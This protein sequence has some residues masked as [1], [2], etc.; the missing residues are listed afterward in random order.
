MWDRPQYAMMSQSS[1]SPHLLGL[2]RALPLPQEAAEVTYICRYLKHCVVFQTFSLTAAV[3]KPEPSALLVQHCYLGPA[4]SSPWASRGSASTLMIP[5]LGAAAA[6]SMFLITQQ[7]WHYQWQSP[8]TT[9]SSETQI[10]KK[11]TS[12]NVCQIGEDKTPKQNKLLWGLCKAFFKYLN[13][14][15]GEKKKKKKEEEW[16]LPAFVRVDKQTHFLFI[17]CPHSRK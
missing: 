6:H 15:K 17:I 1:D 8:Q 10:G 2:F 5:A 12:F 4:F 11:S 13:I 16:Y 14:K 7:S 9:V 3:N